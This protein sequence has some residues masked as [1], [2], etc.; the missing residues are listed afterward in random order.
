MQ[1]K[2]SSSL[3]IE[4]SKLVNRVNRRDLLNFR[5]TKAPVQAPRKLTDVLVLGG[6][7]SVNL[8]QWRGNRFEGFHTI[9]H[10]YVGHGHRAHEGLQGVH[11]KDYVRDVTIAVRSSRE[12][13]YIV[14]H[15]LGVNI[16]SIVAA[17]APDKVLGIIGHGAAPCG[18]VMADTKMILKFLKPHYVQSF[19]GMPFEL[20]PEDADYVRDHSDAQLQ[21]ESGHVLREVALGIKTNPLRTLKC[22]TQLI[23]PT[24]DR[25]NSQP[26]A[27]KIAAWH[28]IDDPIEIDGGHFA[29]CQGYA[30]RAEFMDVVTE[31][32][33][34][35]EKERNTN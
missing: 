14:A 9:V 18:N 21:Q 20:T 25:V 15:S 31:T 11:F 17:L 10:E 23:I 28:R 7:W 13:L 16:A 29:F 24:R 26:T 4:R 2:N 22:R 5:I 34:T 27:W 8:D 33:H 35:W 12:P 19:F 30:A 32:L 6:M 3:L 1:H